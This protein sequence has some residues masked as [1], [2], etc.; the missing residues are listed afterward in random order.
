M[1]AMGAERRGSILSLWAQGT[2]K[3]GRPVIMHHDEEWKKEDE[4]VIQEEKEEVN[5]KA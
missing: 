5:G 4:E 2:D 3:L 1:G